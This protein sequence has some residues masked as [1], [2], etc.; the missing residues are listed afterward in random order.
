MEKWVRTE[1]RRQTE[2]KMLE[3][4]DKEDGEKKSGGRGGV[5]RRKRGEGERDGSGGWCLPGTES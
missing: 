1:T 4:A 2:Y 3:E 5:R